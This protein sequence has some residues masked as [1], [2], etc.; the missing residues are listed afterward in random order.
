MIHPWIFISHSHKIS[1]LLAQCMCAVRAKSLQ[2]SPTLCNPMDCNP[3][4]SSVHGI[5]Q[6]R[7]LEWVVMPS[8]TQCIVKMNNSLPTFYYLPPP[9]RL[10]LEIPTITPALYYCLRT[11]SLHITMSSKSRCF[12]ALMPQNIQAKII[13]ST[14][15]RE[16]SKR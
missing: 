9:P 7:I 3:P 11:L 1:T 5:L 6:A 16:I 10:F 4:G 14:S 15:P 2:S 8:S 13:V 12:S